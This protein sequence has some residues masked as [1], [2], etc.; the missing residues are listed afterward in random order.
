MIQRAGRWGAACLAVTMAALLT[1]CAAEKPKPTPLEPIEQKLGVREAWSMRLGSVKFP[2]SVLARD[3]QFVVAGTDGAVLALDAATGQPR[4]RGD[5]GKAISAGVGSDGRYAA[6]STRDNELVVFDRGEERWRKRLNSRITT[7][8]LV[9]GERVFVMGVDRIVSA[10]DVLD[11]RLLWRL[12]FWAGLIGAPIVLFAAITG[13]VYVFSP[14]IEAWRHTE[15]DH[16]PPKAAVLPLEA[17]RSSRTTAQRQRL[18]QPVLHNSRA[19][20]TL[21]LTQ[22]LCREVLRTG[23]ALGGYGGGLD[24][25]RHLLALEGALLV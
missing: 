12:H 6:V 18:L 3:G 10:F 16:V 14:Q 11:G 7:A 21:D 8:P 19:S 2:L 25:K 9:A 1:A 4:W 5:A 15:M 17:V 20:T 23:G 13:L 22:R 24:A